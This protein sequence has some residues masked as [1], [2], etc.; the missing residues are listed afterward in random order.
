MT[1]DPTRGYS[2]SLGEALVD[3]VAIGQAATVESAT[4]FHKAAG[5]APANVAVGLARLGQR[6]AFIGKVSDDAFGQF[7]R[8]TL[9]SEGVDTVGLIVDSAAHTPLAFVGA[10]RTTERSF[11]FYHQGMA[12]TLLRPDELDRELIAGAR[13]LHFGSVTL[14]ADPGRA[15]TMAAVDLARER[16]AIVSFDPNVRLELWSDE[17]EARA[18]ILEAT[19]RCH[20]LKVSLEELRWLTGIDDPAIGA[21]E[22]RSHGPQLVVVTLGAGGAYHQT[23]AGDGH[24]PGLA[25]EAVDA[26][27]AGDAF[28]AALL[29]E[30]ASM[31]P[32]PAILDDP[33]A[34]SRAIRF[35]TAA[36]ALAT[37]A[38]G[39]IP[40]LPRRD[41]V[42][43]ILA[44]AL[45]GAARPRGRCAEGDDRMDQPREAASHA[46]TDTA[47]S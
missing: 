9:D 28:V 7:L 21:R 27:G 35:A 22:L 39:A 43:R 18:T 4:T 1:S 38:Y 25:V 47:R 10:G 17:D 12:D 2:V 44:D 29:A 42:D 23:A 16:G 45:P 40:S 36:G 37:T 32:F 8:R 34:L 15:A 26:T 30:I 41:A 31:A 11:V 20:I 46:N 13:V 6:C 3:F 14:S 5:G 24:E 19:R 33:A